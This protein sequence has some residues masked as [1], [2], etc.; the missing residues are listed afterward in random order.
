M[1][2][3]ALGLV[4]NAQAFV[5]AAVSVSSIDLG[6]SV[7]KREIGT[8]EPVGFGVAV[9]VAADCTTVKIEAIMATDEAL[10]AGIVV[11]TERTHLAADLPAGALKFVELPPGGP[12]AGWLRYIGIRATPAG[13]NA[14]VTL[15]SWLTSRSLFSVLAKPMAKGYTIS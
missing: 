4:C 13:G 14:T 2:V 8:G 7:P 11:L 15:T 9:D 10:T 3:D 6:A 1:Y 5:A 12:A